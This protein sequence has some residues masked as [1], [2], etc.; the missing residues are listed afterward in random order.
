M[1]LEPPP[2]INE[3]NLF[4][5]TNSKVVFRKTHTCRR[6]RKMTRPMNFNLIERINRELPLSDVLIIDAHCHIGPFFSLFLPKSGAGDVVE[7]MDRM[8]IDKIVASATT[9][10]TSDF[11]KGNRNIL[12]ITK[13]YPGRILA[14]GVFNPHYPEEIEEELEFCFEKNH[15]VGI[16]IH[17]DHGLPYDHENYEKVWEFAQENG[18]IVLAHSWKDDV[19][20]FD[21]LARRYD[22]AEIILGHSC[23]GAR[24]ILFRTCKKRENLYLD[25]T[26]AYRDYGIIE[27]MVS[28][29][30]SERILFGSD[31]NWFSQLH[32]IGSI[33]FS[34]I[35]DNEKLN[36]LGRN[37]NRLLKA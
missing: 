21:K 11:H 32:G 27:K 8:G 26:Y 2:G 33:I 5:G 15:M 30:G 6:R 34:R 29:V 22:K 31:M 20:M 37:M 10:I 36:I 18:M 24:D 14:Y 1:I 16:K 35:S 3:V 23:Y 13:K 7:Q 28:A 12:Q 9:G 4:Q 25:L 17:S 19:S